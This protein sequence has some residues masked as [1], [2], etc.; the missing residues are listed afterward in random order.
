MTRI[1][2]RGNPAT[3]LS[4]RMAQLLVNRRNRGAGSV[5]LSPTLRAEGEEGEIVSI[6]DDATV[7]TD[8]LRSVRYDPRPQRPGDYLHV[9][10]LIGR[11]IRKFALVEQHDIARTPQRLTLMDLLTFGVGDTIHDI[12][13]ERTAFAAPRQVWGKWACKC[14]TTREDTPC[15][16]HDMAG[17]TCRVCNGPVDVYQEV[18]MRDEDLMI[19]GNPDLILY[20][21]HLDALHVTELKSIAH[22]KWKELVR[23]VPDHVI[24]VL[25]YWYLMKKLGYRMT[26]RC[27]ILYITKGY[28]FTEQPYKEFSFNPESII[29]RLEPFLD[30]ARA[31]KEARA[32]G[33]LPV[34]TCASSVA[35]DAKKCEVCSICFGGADAAPKKV[36][37]AEAL[38]GRRT[39]RV[40]RG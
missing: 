6:P 18:S 26:D 22:E 11:C 5:D 7:L 14:G 31:L 36:S 21:A 12:M 17:R 19:V 2:R 35:P 20:L 37:I 34:R 3:P 10:D 29:H 30:D 8:I 4:G 16:L 9:S 28:T 24:Q 13:K 23:P 15:T 27:T 1:I 39:I 32:G 25:F 33:P 38:G 40:A